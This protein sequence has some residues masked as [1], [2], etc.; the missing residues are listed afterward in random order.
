V[1]PEIAAFLRDVKDHPDDDTPRLI[2]A[3]WLQDHDDPAE[4]DRGE[5]IRA[6]CLRMRL[7][8]SHPEHA[9]FLARERLLLDRHAIEW[10]GPLFEGPI[11]YRFQRGLLRLVVHAPELNYARTG[12]PEEPGSHDLWP[13]VE[14]LQLDADSFRTLEILADW[15][16]CPSLPG[17]DLHGWDLGRGRLSQFLAEGRRSGDFLRS[18]PHLDCSFCRLRA[19]GAAALT[20]LPL[21]ALT[22]LRLE[23][24]GLGDIG[25]RELLAGARWPNLTTLNLRWNQ[26]TDEGVNVLASAG[27]FRLTTLYL[28]SNGISLR[29]GTA[30]LSSSSL[31]A[32]RT[33]YLEHNPISEQEAYDLRRRFGE[34]VRF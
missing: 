19:M 17:L 18:L 13:W 25:V 2:L 3:D 33:L 7:D 27:L 31:P 32:L 28:G 11:P 5:F 8:E 20:T 15:L 26:V 30:L 34:R 14:T 12:H 9:G 16:R 10:L 4:R 22:T 23:D 24:N 1:R 29:G 6:Q 21:A